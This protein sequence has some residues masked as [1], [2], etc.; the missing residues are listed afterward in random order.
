MSDEVPHLSIQERN[1]AFANRLHSFSIVNHGYLGLRDFF[2]AAFPFF[3]Q[4]ASVVINVNHLVK[5]SACFIAKFEKTIASDEGD[6]IET[7]ILYLKTRNEVVDFETDLKF[8]YDDEMVPAI[9]QRIDDVE[10]RG[11]GFRLAAI[12]ELNI[13]LSAFDPLSGSSYIPLPAF[14]QK[15]TSNHQC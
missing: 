2:A 10:L 5:I 6:R 14:L 9:N 8:F 7:Q 1:F 15:K 4:N 12:Q 11:S 13:Q 3:E